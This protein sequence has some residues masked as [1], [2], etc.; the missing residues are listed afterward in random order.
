MPLL[1]IRE[2]QETQ[3]NCHKSVDEFLEKLETIQLSPGSTSNNPS[4]LEL[5]NQIKLWQ[6]RYEDS[7]SNA[8]ARDIKRHHYLKWN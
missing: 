1:P 6:R 3:Q 8:I 5:K 2:I 7:R 4:T